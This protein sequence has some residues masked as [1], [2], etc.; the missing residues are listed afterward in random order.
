MQSLNK[1]ALLLTVRYLG[2]LVPRQVV[3]LIA[4]P[5]QRSKLKEEVGIK[6]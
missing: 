1:A 5:I 2:K 3:S 4:A 6:F